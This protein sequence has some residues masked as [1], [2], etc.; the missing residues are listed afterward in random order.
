MKK[1]LLI[2]FLVIFTNCEEEKKEQKPTLTAAFCEA[3]HDEEVCRREGCQYEKTNITFVGPDNVC[4]KKTFGGSA[5]LHANISAL[6]D[7]LPAG[8][9]KVMPNGWTASILLQGTGFIDGWVYQPTVYDTGTDHCCTVDP[10]SCAEPWEDFT[11][12]WFPFEGLLD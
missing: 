3:I 6:N 5:C 11:G 8:Y 9:G 7:G 1:L 4:R 2:S 12:H 10:D